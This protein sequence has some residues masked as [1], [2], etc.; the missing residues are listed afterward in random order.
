MSLKN[1]E[2]LTS[3]SIRILAVLSELPVRRRFPRGLKEI[4]EISPSWPSNLVM[5][6]LVAALKTL[7]VP[8]SVGTL[9]P[10]E[11]GGGCG[12]LRGQGHS[13]ILIRQISSSPYLFKY[14]DL[15]NGCKNY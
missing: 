13:H 3:L 15:K 1:P 2:A 10:A 9:T 11:A 12:S 14:A 7:A 6:F 8:A 4:F 5:H